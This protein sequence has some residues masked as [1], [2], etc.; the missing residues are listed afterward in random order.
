MKK[1]EIREEERKEI[2]KI[3]M[4]VKL[5]LMK[6]DVMIRMIRFGS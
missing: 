5:N 6:L 1:E 2:M 4:M 3:K